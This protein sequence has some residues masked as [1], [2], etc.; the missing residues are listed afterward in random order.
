MQCI[1]Y[2]AGNLRRKK[3]K[4]IKENYQIWGLL[5][6]NANRKKKYQTAA[7]E[8]WSPSGI[9]GEVRT[10]DPWTFSANTINS[11]KLCLLCGFAFVYK[12]KQAVSCGFCSYLLDCTEGKFRNN[13]V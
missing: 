1:R 5:L 6:N 9:H 10:S 13:G 2:A 8:S 7:F 11:R 12:G 3:K 4:K